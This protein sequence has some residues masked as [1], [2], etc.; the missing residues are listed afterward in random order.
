MCGFGDK[1][2]RVAGLTDTVAIE[3]R[4]STWHCTMTVMNFKLHKNVSKR[5]LQNIS[6]I[7]NAL[8]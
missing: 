4:L 3:L 8:L 6:K 1:V 2:R 5:S 7:T